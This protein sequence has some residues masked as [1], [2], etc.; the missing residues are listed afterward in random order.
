MSLW[1]LQGEAKEEPPQPKKL[2]GNVKPKV[3]EIGLKGKALIRSWEK[4][5]LKAYRHRGDVPTIGWGNTFY[6]DGTKVKLGDVITQDRADFLFGFIVK[7]FS[8]EV[9]EIVKSSV[10]QNQFD[11]LVS[12]AYNVGTPSLQKST[13]LKMVNSNPGN[14]D[15]FKYVLDTDGIAKKGSCEFLKWTSRHP[16]FVKGLRRRRQA[17]CDLYASK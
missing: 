12:F 4:C 14:P 7:R 17:E 16:Q 8:D 10:T 5:S 6:E 2:W 13:L 1:K 9:A 15:I 11:A 3:M